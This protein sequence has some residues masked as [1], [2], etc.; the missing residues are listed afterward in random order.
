MHHQQQFHIRI[1]SAFGLIGLAH[2]QIVRLIP[3]VQNGVD[4]ISKSGICARCY[5][6]FQKGPIGSGIDEISPAGAQSCRYDFSIRGAGPLSREVGAGER[7]GEQR[8]DDRGYQ[9]L[10]GREVML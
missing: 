4:A 3:G 9:F 1:V 6:Y 7:T 2:L 8:F 5:D 10:F